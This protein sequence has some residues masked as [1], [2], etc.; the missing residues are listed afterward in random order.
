MI[1]LET[2]CQDIVDKLRSEQTARREARRD[3]QE[4][5]ALIC[6]AALGLLG[7]A[8]LAYLLVAVGR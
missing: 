2:R 4:R 6:A 1:D 7:C 3:R 8:M 5:V